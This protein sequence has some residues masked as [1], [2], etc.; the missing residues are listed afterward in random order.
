MKKI[1]SIVLLITMLL[2]GILFLTGCTLTLETTDN[3]VSASV[4]GETTEKVDG[5]LDWIKERFSR[6][7]DV[8]VKTKVDTDS[9]TVTTTGASEKI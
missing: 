8:E 3:S 5:I 6:V 4:D 1:I 9:I 2:M 7:F